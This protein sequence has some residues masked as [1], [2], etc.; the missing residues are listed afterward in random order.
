[1]FILTLRQRP[2]VRVKYKSIK[3][4]K[5]KEIPISTIPRFEVNHTNYLKYVIV[6]FCC[7]VV[8]CY[9][10]LFVVLLLL[11]LLLLLYLLYFYC[12]RFIVAAFVALLLYCY[13]KEISGQP[14]RR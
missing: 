11:L 6:V 14:E 9:I 5:I 12:I 4:T 3:N 8:F 7:I 1:M 13:K 2:S 10:V